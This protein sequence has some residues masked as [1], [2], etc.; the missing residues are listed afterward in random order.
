MNTFYPSYIEELDEAQKEAVLYD[1]GPALVIAGAGSGK[2]RV[3]VAKVL[4]L[5]DLGYAPSQI[6]ALTFTNKAARE[7][8]ARIYTHAGAAARQ[9]MM[10]TFHSVFS[11]ILRT[12]AD[13]L[14]YQASFSIYDTTDSKNLVKAIIKRLELD[15]KTYKPNVV[16]NRISNAKNRLLSPQAYLS[17]KEI[18][19]YNTQSHV[20]RIGEIYVIYQ[21]ELK[22][23]NAMDFDDLLFQTNILLRDHPDV[24]Q[25]VK[26]HTGYLLIDEYQDTNFAQYMIARQIMGET[27]NIFVVGDD[28]QSI[29]S[30]RGANISNILTFQQTFKGTKLFKLEQN[31]RS[32][33]TIVQVANSL[34]SH[35]EAQIPKEIY[36]ENET[37]EL[38][39]IHEALTADAEAEWAADCI[40]RE[41]GKGLPFSECTVLYRTNAQSRIIEQEFRRMRIPFRIYGGHAFFD[42]K[43]IKDVIAY[44]KLAV[45]PSDNE[46]YSRVIN[47]PR[48]GIGDVTINRLKET[49]T[50]QN[51]SLYEQTSPE[52][53]SQVPVNASTA[54]KLTAFHELIKNFVDKASEEISFSEIARNIISESGVAADILGDN[55]PEGLKRQENF[56]ELFN[57]IDEYQI[58]VTEN[59]QAPSLQNY[60][61]EVALMTDQDTQQADQKDVVT[62]MTIHS[63]K[64]LEFD[65]VY[66]LGLEE[67]LFPSALCTT[68]SELEEERR[69]FYVA[70]TRARKK[71]RICYARQR[72]RN[73]SLEIMRPSRFLGELSP[74]LIE[75]TRDSMIDPYGTMRG[76]PHSRKHGDFLPTDFPQAASDKYLQNFD[77]KSPSKSPGRSGQ[78]IHVGTRSE[79]DTLRSY[80][81]IGSL[82]VGDT[83][84]HNK[85]G[86][87]TINALEGEGDNARATVNFNEYGIKKMMLKFAKLSK[88]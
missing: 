39:Q 1:G 11:R 3:L 33:Q 13:R 27:G 77:K 7:M 26:R 55:T 64:G 38:I 22:K 43:E 42:Y 67:Q 79:H 8:R 74:T 50:N 54:K 61:S 71:C 24:S 12:Y 6:M 36:S 28:A 48:R 23:N 56:K 70:I 63:A 76:S 41:A 45:N 46:A 2:T 30:F 72:Y 9:V 65:H 73:G 51:R 10:G 69:L 21:E 47:Y 37:G 58:K 31:Y 84:M 75:R 40:K 49:A 85:F 14:G 34:I 25:E 80:D 59:E 52:N 17:N 5:I 57:S 32:T 15:D 87:G 68:A 60:L 81:S 16:A 78:K 62:L 66:I 20:P 53:I 4:H 19:I 18:S 44:L 86:I 88:L 83:V 29:Y 82:N 35:N